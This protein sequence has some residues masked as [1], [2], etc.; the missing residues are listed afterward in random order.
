MYSSK[1]FIVAKVLKDS[2]GHEHKV[3]AGVAGS[4]GEAIYLIHEDDPTTD[5][6]HLVIHGS[7]WEFGAERYD[8]TLP[9]N[10]SYLIYRVETGK[11]LDPLLTE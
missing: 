10:D 11:P 7:H 2:T 6:N 3:L 1:I 9:L 4:L 8:F 5:I